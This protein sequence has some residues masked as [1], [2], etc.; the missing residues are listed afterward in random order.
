MLTSRLKMLQPTPVARPAEATA[1][2]AGLHCPQAVDMAE[3]A[4]AS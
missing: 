3:M 2:G 1:A 4:T